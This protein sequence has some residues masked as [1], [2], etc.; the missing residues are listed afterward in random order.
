MLSPLGM[1]GENILFGLMIWS[2]GSVPLA[3]FLGNIIGFGEEP[4]Q[5]PRGRKAEPCAHP[6]V[7]RAREEQLSALTH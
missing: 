1:S 4:T 5:A 6:H 7:L 2:V 3:L